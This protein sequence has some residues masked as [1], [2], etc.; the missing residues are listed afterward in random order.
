[1]VNVMMDDGLTEDLITIDASEMRKKWLAVTVPPPGWE[2]PTEDAAEEISDADKVF[3]C[4][5]KTSQRDVLHEYDMMGAGMV[6]MVCG[7]S[8]IRTRSS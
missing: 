1:M 8:S 4:E 6:D 7:P 5:V 3:E 2:V